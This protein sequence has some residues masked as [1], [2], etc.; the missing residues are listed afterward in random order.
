MSD[1]LPAAIECPV[2]GSSKLQNSLE[3]RY[4]RENRLSFSDCVD[5]RLT[6]ANPMPSDAL[7]TK[8]NEALVRLYHRGRSFEQ[9]FRDARQAYLRGKVLAAKLRGW[10]KRGRFLEIGS[11]QGFLSLGVKEN[12]AWDVETLEIA[13]ALAEFTRSTLG[14]PCHQGTLETSELKKGS[15]DF[16]LCHD[17]IEHINKPEEFLL[18]LSALLAPGG[19]VQILTPNT[20]QDFAYNRRAHAAGKAPTIVLNHIMNFSPVSLKIALEKAQLRIR[21]MHCY[22]VKHALKDFGVFGLGQ[23]DPNPQSP[24]IAET[25]QLPLNSLLGEWTPVRLQQLREHPKTSWNYAFWKEI[26]PAFFR[27]K[28]PPALGIGHEIYALAEKPGR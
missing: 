7:I 14:I 17:L 10:K 5:C 15:Y 8:G 16:I 12:C 28:L 26:L 3:L 23:P 25:M 21:K 11:Y 6:F 27:L 20:I 1:F 4:W 13:P 9:E 18:Q 24:S 2:C 19:R 22:G